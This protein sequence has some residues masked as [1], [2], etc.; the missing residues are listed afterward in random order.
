MEENNKFGLYTEPLD[1][2]FSFTKLKDDIAEVIDLSNNFN[3]YLEHEKYGPNN[4]KNS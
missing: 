1:S 2:E 3:K 4:I